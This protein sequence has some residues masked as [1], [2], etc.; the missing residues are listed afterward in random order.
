MKPLLLWYS[1]QI[2]TQ[3]KRKTVSQFSWWT[4]LQDHKIPVH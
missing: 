4:Q 1:N 3:Q 2:N